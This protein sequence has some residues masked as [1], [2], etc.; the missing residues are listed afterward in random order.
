MLSFLAL[1][2]DRESIGY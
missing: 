1:T 2:P